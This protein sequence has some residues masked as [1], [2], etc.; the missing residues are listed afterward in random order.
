MDFYHSEDNNKLRHVVNWIVDI[1]VVI[2]F[3]WFLVYAYGTQI[4]IA[5]H[6]MLPLLASEDVVF[7]DRLGY[8]FGNPD[9]FDVVVFQRED[10]KM[11]V[12]RVVGL[13]GETVQIKNDGIYIDGERLKEPAGPGRISLAGLA[14]K[15]I[16]LGAQ[17]YF[18]LGDNRDSSEDSRF[19]NIGNVSRDQI[20][21]KVWFRMLPLV[22]MELIRS[23]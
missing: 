5:G 15:P 16:K 19:A 7:M 9:R 17:E 12:K 2:A 10:Q 22:K 11:N 1:V 6:S 8:D 23:K 18:L 14:E 20:Q 21:G 13:P 4:V 3:A